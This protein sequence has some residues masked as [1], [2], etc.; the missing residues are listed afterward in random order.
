AHV[1]AGLRSR[2][3]RNPF[4]EEANRRL[5]G[6]VTDL[7]FAPTQLARTN[8]RKEYVSAEEIVVT[9]NTVVDA[10]RLLV[11]MNAL[12]APLPPRIPESGRMILVTSHR[13]ESWGRELENI[14]GA[15]RD[16]TEAYSDVHIVYPVHMN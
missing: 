11:E 15:L 5:A 6:V 10:V 1:E 12:D 7:N 16:L 4:P 9:G 8:L 3:L 13:R 2:D 14:C